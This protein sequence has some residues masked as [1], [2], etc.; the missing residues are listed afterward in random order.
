MIREG[1]WKMIAQSNHKRT[2][3]DPIHL[4]DLEQDPGEELDRI[5]DL[6]CQAVVQDL[7]AKYRRIV[8]SRCS[9]VTQRDSLH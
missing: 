1:A 4:Y 6:E 8:E 2:V 7:L 5:Q 9:T 3:F